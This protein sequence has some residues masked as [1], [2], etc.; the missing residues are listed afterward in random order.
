MEE[1]KDMVKVENSDANILLESIIETDASF[2]IFNEAQRDIRV[3]P[4]SLKI[5]YD[6]YM[7]NLKKHKILWKEILVKYVGEDNASDYQM[8]YRFDIYKQV[9]FLLNN[10]GGC[11]SCN[12][13]K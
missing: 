7:R 11:E 12:L 8:L 6:I 3:T 4:E 9:I 10:N 5:L 2:Q 1:L 13:K